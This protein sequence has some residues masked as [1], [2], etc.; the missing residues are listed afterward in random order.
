MW[1]MVMEE[2]GQPLALERVADPAPSPAGVVLAV[3]AVGVCRTDWHLWH[4]H[5]DWVGIAVEAPRVL[6]HECAGTVVAVGSSVTGLEVG[7]RVVAPFHVACGQCSACLVGQNN[8]CAA[9]DYLGS[10]IDGGFAQYVHVPRA[11]VNCRRLP[12]TV[13][14]STAAMFGCR[15]GSA[16][17]ALTD[18]A[19][20]RAGEWVVVT[21]AGGGVGTSAVQ[22]AA[23][24]GASV[25]AVDLTEDKLRLAASAGASVTVLGGRP[26]G[27]EQVLDATGGGVNVSIGA[28]SHSACVAEGISILKAG[29]R[30][31]QIGM[32]DAQQ[33]GQVPL[34][35]DDLVAREIQV[36]GA[37]GIP[38]RSLAELI[39]FVASGR[40]D[41]EA[42]ITSRLGLAEV[43]G[44]FRAMDGA[45]APGFT[46]VDTFPKGQTA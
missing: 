16:F 32:T 42:L 15:Y 3:D 26:G 46:V 43:N 31:V 1:A 6:G 44:T 33:R 17:H 7:Q 39:R 4:G 36:A 8:I 18:V 2:I 19:R 11:E 40:C 28:T 25:V 30:H 10:G 41:P 29:G 24:M 22:L 45:G 35:L 14:A 5:W 38:H 37:S 13:S 12:D 20:L 21:G 9:A 23:A 27:T 34:P